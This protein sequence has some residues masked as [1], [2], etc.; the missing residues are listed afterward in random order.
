ML[1]EQTLAIVG[2]LLGECAAGRR[3]RQ[4]AILKLGKLK[5]VEPIPLRR[6][7]PVVSGASATLLG[8]SARS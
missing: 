6:G 8:V 7:I 4:G 2:S 1:V 5:Q 3:E